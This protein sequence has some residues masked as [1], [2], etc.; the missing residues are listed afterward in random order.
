MSLLG[1]LL[2]A[3]AVSTAVIDVS[4]SDDVWVYPHAGRQDED[5][6]LRVWGGG[7][8]ALGT[9]SPGAFDFSYSLLKFTLPEGKG[10]PKSAL[11]IVNQTADPA[12]S[13]D[14][15]LK[16]PLEARAAKADWNEQ[17]WTFDMAI[18][19]VPGKEEKD[20]L[21]KGKR[22]E[23]LDGKPVK[24]TINL[25]AGPAQVDWQGKLTLALTSR[26]DPE[27]MGEGRMYKLYSRQAPQVNLRPV[28]QLTY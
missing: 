2:M 24:I 5:P 18:K 9:P 19:N 14:D 22:E 6:F 1:S 20:I 16:A 8:Y 26:M 12:Y 7:D 11:L 25:L 13:E 10:T 28:L 21:G 17:A 15:F 23:V 3:T 4:P 27:S